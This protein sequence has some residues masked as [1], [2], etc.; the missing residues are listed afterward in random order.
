[1]SE[2]II[3]AN[4]T[5]EG[6]SRVNKIYLP[7]RKE[8]EFT[9]A[10]DMDGIPRPRGVTVTPKPRSCAHTNPAK[11]HFLKRRRAVERIINASCAV[12]H[13]EMISFSPGLRFLGVVIKAACS[14]EL[15]FIS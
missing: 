6:Q 2:S 9:F 12:V 11:S 3:M 7:E 14:I 5:D 15:H 10:M 13:R 8:E 1:M 4:L